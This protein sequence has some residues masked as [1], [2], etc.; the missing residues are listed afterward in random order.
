MKTQRQ[1]TGRKGEDEACFY[2]MGLGMTILKRNSRHSHLETDIIA[3]AADGLHFVEVKTVTAPYLSRPELKV[4][5]QKRS[6]MI[7]AAGAWL[8]S[9][10]RKDLPADI[11]VFLDVITV[12]FDGR[13]RRIEYFPDAF[14]RSVL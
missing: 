3:L 9:E 8:L 12:V 1:I 4:N 10:E 2:L 6:R 13:T 14:T 11:E 7:R 5:Y